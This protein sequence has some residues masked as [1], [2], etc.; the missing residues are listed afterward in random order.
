MKIEIG[1]ECF[2]TL[3]SN[4][5]DILDLLGFDPTGNIQMILT[6]TDKNYDKSFEWLSKS[7]NNGCAKGQYLFRRLL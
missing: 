3:K 2:F 4:L 1:S 5:T 6:G 7:A